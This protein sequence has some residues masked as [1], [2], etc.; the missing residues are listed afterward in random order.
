M[1][2]C[3]R[4]TE[5]WSRDRQVQLPNHKLPSIDVCLLAPSLHLAHV[6]ELGLVTSAEIAAVRGLR[7]WSSSTMHDV[8]DSS[9]VTASF[10]CCEEL[11]D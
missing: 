11:T 1:E 2:F 6:R 5:A 9:A 4:K 8:S 7:C 3:K 10:Q